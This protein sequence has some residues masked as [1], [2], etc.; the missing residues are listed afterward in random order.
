[1]A[2][3][4]LQEILTRCP[5]S[6]QCL[7]NDQ[8]Q[9]DEVTM[10]SPFGA[11]LANIVMSKVEQTYLKDTINDLDFYARSVFKG[12]RRLPGRDGTASAAERRFRE[13]KAQSLRR[14]VTRSA[15]LDRRRGLLLEKPV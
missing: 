7:Y 6:V 14:Q 9:L 12:L 4:T 11:F 15:A 10:G 1:M 2:V 13:S 3:E 5:Q 8:R